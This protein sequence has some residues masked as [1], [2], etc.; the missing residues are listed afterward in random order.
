[1][2]HGLMPRL[3]PGPRRSG[4][5]FFFC[6]T[7]IGSNVP[8]LYGIARQSLQS[9]PLWL[10]R[11][12]G[13]FFNAYTGRISRRSIGPVQCRGGPKAGFP[14]CPSSAPDSRIFKPSCP[15]WDGPWDWTPNWAKS[16]EEA[17]KF[18]SPFFME[19]TTSSFDPNRQHAILL[20][21]SY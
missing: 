13:V 20:K 7:F 16:Q 6:S 10:Y 18:Q 3:L 9:L 19:T 17:R 4:R 8:S 15:F 21:P 5:S 11:P 12:E 14:G 2:H 1:M